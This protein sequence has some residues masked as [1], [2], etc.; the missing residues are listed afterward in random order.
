M[1]A[2]E[3]KE[4]GS[5]HF[6]AFMSARTALFLYRFS[7]ATIMPNKK[8]SQNFS[9]LQKHLFLTHLWS[10]THLG[11]LWLLED[12]WELT[13]VG[14]AQM[15]QLVCLTSVPGVFHPLAQRSGTSFSWNDRGTKNKWKH[16][17]PLGFR[18]RTGTPALLPCSIGQS[19]SQGQLRFKT[20][21]PSP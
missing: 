9:G 3:H 11:S 17:D 18:L 21:I 13:G 6:S 8:S 20:W 2:A 5:L 15:R 12:K 4:L 1:K 7:I 14:W 10:W 19:K 16:E